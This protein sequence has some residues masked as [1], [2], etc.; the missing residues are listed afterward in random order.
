MRILQIIDSL[1][2]GGAEKMAVNYAN[3]L[4]NLVEFSGIVTTRKEGFLK[5][6]LNPNVDYLFLNRKKTVDFSALFR[7]K[8]YCNINQID[9]LQAHSSSYFTAV[10]LKLLFPKIKVIWHDHNGLSEFLSSR[11]SLVLKLFSYFFE[12]IVV[13]ND[14][15]K[16][17]A[18]ATLHCKSVLYLPNFTVLNQNE[19]KHTTLEGIDGK[20]ILCLANL[21]FQKNHFL[22]L[23]V[24]EKLKISHPD[25]SFHLIGKDF[26]DAYSANIKNLIS[27]KNLSESVFIYGS[28][29]DTQHCLTQS[30]IGIL[31]SQSEGLP[32]SVLEYGLTKK[33]VV[34]TD[35]GELPLIINNGVNGFIVRKFDA[36]EFYQSLVTLIEDTE[37]RT[38]FG[39]QLNQT[40]LTN[41]SEKAILTSYLNWISKL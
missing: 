21:R 15:L 11:K 10:L 16:N 28:K 20:R 8:N 32:V 22:L 37:M 9:Y 4:A 38:Y 7:L 41:H 34:L 25:W 6:Q 2:I 40:I 13:V 26:Q 39:V 24:A 3:G 14:Q 12:G 30:E 31:T 27:D 29:E 18:V 23:E 36:D 17:W 19:I 1:E 5:K 33:A 35:V